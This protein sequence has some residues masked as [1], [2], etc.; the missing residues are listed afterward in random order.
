MSLLLPLALASAGEPPHYRQA[1][2]APGSKS[3]LD[4]QLGSWWNVCVDGNSLY[5]HWIKAPLQTEGQAG[6]LLSAYL[7]STANVAI[8]GQTWKNMRDKPEDADNMWLEGKR[9][10]LIVGEDTNAAGTEDSIEEI[11]AT[12]KGYLADREA[13]HKWDKVILCGALPIYPYGNAEK[14]AYQSPRIL[15]ISNALKA[16][17]DL[18][19]VYVDFRAFAPEWFT[20]RTNYRA[21]FMDSLDTCFKDQ[22]T[23]AADGIH[24]IGAPR[25]RMGDALAAAIRKAVLGKGSAPG[26]TVGTRAARLKREA[27]TS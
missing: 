22:A 23:Q 13:K 19:D 15:E 1:K 12:A 7:M 11:V 8:P 18:Y 3:H 14:A 26:I 24:P 5:A 17:T 21:K 2:P 6:K 4:T 16:D 27:T 20:A 10:L 9:N 25:E